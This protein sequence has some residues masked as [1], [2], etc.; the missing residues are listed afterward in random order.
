METALRKHAWIG[1]NYARLLFN[2]YPGFTHAGAAGDGLDTDSSG[3]TF[4]INS[5]SWAV[6]SGVATEAE[7]ASMLDLIE[8]KLETP[9]GLKLVSPND[10][11]RV[12]PGV[13]S[14]EYFPGDR[15]NGAVFKH[16]AMMA[17]AALFDAAKA[18]QDP[19]LA[20]RLAGKAWWML[21]LA[22]PSRSMSDPFA[23]AGNPRFCTQYNNSETGENIGPSSPSSRAWASSP[24][25]AACPSIRPYGRPTGR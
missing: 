25:P 8:K 7:I 12:V 2:K 18:V 5:F 20:R 10:L 17:T 19:A 13:A 22:R 16:A 14:S 3:G 24:S 21:D 15:E 4:F 23:L 11:G 6:L 9:Y 1:G